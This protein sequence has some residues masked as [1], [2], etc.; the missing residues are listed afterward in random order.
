MKEGVFMNELELGE[1]TACL[2]VG[3]K[4]NLTPLIE[5]NKPEFKRQYCPDCLPEI[6]KGIPDSWKKLYYFGPKGSVK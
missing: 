4:K 1:C 2:R 6:E 3:R 5:R